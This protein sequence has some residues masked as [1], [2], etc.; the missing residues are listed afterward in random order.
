M[1]AVQAG[2]WSDPSTW[3]GGTV[4]AAGDLVSIGEGMDVVL[5]VSPPALNGVNLDGK[6]SF[7]NE[8]DLELTTEWILM[9]G[10]LQIGSENR[11]HTRNATITLTD[12]IPDENIMGMG[13]RGIMIMGGVL[14]L[15][16]DRENAWTKLAA[17]AEAGSSHIEVLDA[18]GWRVGDTIVLAS[19]DF[20]PRQA[21]KRVVT[22][23]NGNTVSLDQPLEY[24]HFGAIT[25]GVDERGEVGLLT[26]N[27]KVQ[28]SAD[29][30]DSWFGGHIMAMAGST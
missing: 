29:A 27:I 3:A 30:E 12:T 6:L 9:R 7:S 26:R 28:A 13:D 16:G 15:Y 11:P 18:G 5:D 20:N 25:F 4:P 21:E 2:Q 23:I 19:T 8:H 22:A 24:M 17:T 1:S 10:E 14:S